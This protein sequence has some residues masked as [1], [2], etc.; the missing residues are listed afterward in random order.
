MPQNSYDYCEN[1]IVA[2][3]KT[4]GIKEGDNLFSHS[5]IGFFGSLQNANSAIDFYNIFKRAIFKVIGSEGTLIVPTF[6]YSFCKKQDFDIN[7][8]KGVGGFFSELLRK[9]PDAKRSEDANFSVAA[10]GKNALFFTENMPEHSFGK[11]SF[12]DRFYQKNGKICNFNFDSGSTYIHYVEKQLNVPYRYDKAFTGFLIKHNQ[13]VKKTFYHFVYDL[14]KPNNEACFTKFDKK[15]KEMNI[16]QVSNLGRG[17]VLCLSAVD[18]Y[19]LIKK[20]LILEPAFLIK[21]KN[22]E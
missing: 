6:S 13:K 8:T 1:D 20:Q 15:A 17:Q 21:G 16:T 9:D 19:N 11:D 5:N 7:N 14:A 18:T 12:F 3:L 4:L 10:L 2:S 22:I